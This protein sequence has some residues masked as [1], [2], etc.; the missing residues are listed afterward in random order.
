MKRQGIGLT[1]KLYWR[2]SLN[3]RFHCFKKMKGGGFVSLCGRLERKRSGGQQCRRPIPLRR[4]GACDGHEM[5]R[6]GWDE[7]GPTSPRGL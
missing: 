1:D 5:K 7:S 3:G 4:C 2:P 6:R